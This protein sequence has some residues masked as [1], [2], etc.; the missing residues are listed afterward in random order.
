M[1]DIS[2]PHLDRRQFAALGLGLATA[3]ATPS[4][5]AAA[6]PRG[7]PWLQQLRNRPVTIGMLLFEGLD[8]VDFT[9]PFAVLARVPQA[10]LKV[11]GPTRSPVR[12]HKG[13]MLTPE[14]A[15]AEAGDVDVLVVP[16]GPGQ[17]QQMHNTPLLETI[18][19]QVR[20]GRALF[21]VCTGALLCG[22]A[23]VL[24]GRRATT[25]W[26]AVH[27]LPYFGA[28]AEASRVVVDGD[29]VFAAGLTAGFDGALT[30]AALM[31]G[32]EVAQ[33]IQLDLQYAPEP[34]FRAGNPDIA[35]AAVLEAV[36]GRYAA[37]TAKRLETAQR[38]AAGK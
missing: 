17:E 16:G 28:K 27:L 32:D 29:L 18:A 24:R 11:I 23:G 13:L 38:F 15:L 22:A 26:S 5:A 35:P 4:I 9:G 1:T 12:D 2:R 19:R 31:R 6:A 21:S 36:R 37:L 30:L 14:V 3:V 8:Q 34:P 20:E 33:Q 10:T 7:G 25:H